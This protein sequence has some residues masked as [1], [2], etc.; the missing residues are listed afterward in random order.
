MADGAACAKPKSEEERFLATLAGL[1]KPEVNPAPYQASVAACLGHA[2]EPVR[3]LA[4]AVL[5]RIGAPAADALTGALSPQQPVSVRTIAAL[6][7]A[8]LGAAAEGGVRELCR[9]LTDTDEGLR[10]AAGAALAKIGAP[11]VP[12]LRL[13]LRFTNPEP[14]DA[15]VS[16]LTFI[17]PPA[18][19]AAPELETLAGRT[20][21][22][23]QLACIAALVRVTGDAG[24]GLPLLLRAIAAPEPATRK[25]AL[26]RIG[27]LQQAG[28]PAEAYL[29]HAFGDPEAAVR[30][31]AALAV[32]RTRI[33]AA[34]SLT[35]LVALLDDPAPEVRVSACVAL[36]ALGRDAAPALPRL[37]AHA[38]D[39]DANVAAAAGAAVKT[40]E[41]AR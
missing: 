38:Q 3:Q 37:Q 25:L 1:L 4:A 26:D 20:P 22:P 36:A 13:M 21:L 23:L 35:A 33:P 9:C 8:S 34:H 31:A 5:G 17:G 7:L 29:L 16:A 28:A 32:A 15:A 10:K 24:R 40:I 19:V 11:A 27:E 30:A 2:A 39:N 12:A 14:L 6:G 41:E 18:A